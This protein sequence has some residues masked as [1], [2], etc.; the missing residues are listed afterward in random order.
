M[1]RSPIAIEDI[2]R[3]DTVIAYERDIK[4]SGIIY[5]HPITNTSMAGPPIMNLQLFKALCGDA[6]MNQVFIVS[7]MWQGVGPETGSTREHK[8]SSGFW[9]SLIRN[10]AKFGRL[11]RDSPTEARRIIAQM[12]GGRPVLLLIQEEL[13]ERRKSIR[14]TAAGEKVYSMHQMEIP[15]NYTEFPES[16][17]APTER[18][19]DPAPTKTPRGGC[20]QAELEVVESPTIPSSECATK[21]ARKHDR[22]ES[23]DIWRWFGVVPNRRGRNNAHDDDNSSTQVPQLTSATGRL[24]SQHSGGEGSSIPPVDTYS[25]YEG[26]TPNQKVPEDDCLLKTFSEVL[27]TPEGQLTLQG[28]KGADAQLMIDYI[29]SVLLRPKLPEGLRKYSRIMLYRLCE[30]SM[31]YPRC[32][33]LKDIEKPD[34][35]AACGGFGD[36]YKGRRGNKTLCLK[37]IRI[38]PPELVP[39]L[40]VCAK[41]GIVWGEPRHPNI[42]PFYGVYYFGKTRE[43]FCFVSPWMERGDL[44]T[45]LR[46]NPSVPR[47]PYIHDIASGLEYV[48]GENMIH[49]DMKGANVLVNDSGRACITDFGL[50]MILFDKTLPYARG[51][52]TALRGG[53]YRWAAPELLQEGARPTWASDVWAF[54]GVCYEI[55]VGGIPFPQCKTDYQVILRLY[56]GD[57]PIGSVRPPHIDNDMWMLMERCCARNFEERPQFG[58]ILV[59]LKGSPGA[60]PREIPAEPV[61]EGLEF[62]NEM[63]KQEHGD[64]ID[65]IRIKHILS[66]VWV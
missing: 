47:A 29:H 46:K 15:N 6:A 66:Q 48:H 49:G 10:G 5:F 9:V 12:R 59:N 8:L 38:Q 24:A 28:L 62:Q 55:L 31:L 17:D 13:S 44:A 65:L 40:K 11:E 2:N 26:S 45:Y 39:T 21:K 25:G 32:Y 61:T 43:Q 64:P 41:E 3:N 4:L 54:A 58:E 23:Y 27:K 7:T 22:S 14:D 52:T 30:D 34:L 35:P 42:L 56:E 53:S 33:V 16:L 51:Q 20:M 19:Q 1:P 50:S 18:P 37:I 60:D 57:L 36:I 63:R